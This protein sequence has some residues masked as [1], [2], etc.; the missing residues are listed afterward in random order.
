MALKLAVEY[1]TL[2]NKSTNAFRVITYSLLAITATLSSATASGQSNEVSKPTNPTPVIAQPTFYSR[3]AIVC[4][5]H[6]SLMSMQSSNQY[7]GEQRHLYK[8]LGPERY[9]LYYGDLPTAPNPKYYGCILV[10]AGTPML[11]DPMSKM[12]LI[13]VTVKLINGKVF[14]GVT[15]A[16]MIKRD[17]RQK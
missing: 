12:P 8:V 10:K 15:S 6:Q 9:K 3:E 14:K 1:K 5:N 4:E 2:I 16:N 11:L 7:V 13:I 17:S